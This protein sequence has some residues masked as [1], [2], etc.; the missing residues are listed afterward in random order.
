MEGDH[1]LQELMIQENDEGQRLDKYLSKYLKEAPKSFLYKMLRKKNIVLNKK[2]ADGTERL[3]KGDFVQLFLSEETIAKFRGETVLNG[4]ADEPDG[5]MPENPLSVQPDVLYE[6]KDVIFFSKPAG[7][8]SQKARPEDQSM[9]E[10]L[11]WYLLQQGKLK[12]EELITFHPGV[13]NRLDRNTS[14][15]IAAGKT[16]KGLQAMSLVIQSHGLKKY[17]QCIVK[18]EMKEKEEK[19][20]QGYLV[21]NHSHNRVVIQKEK[22]DGADYICTRYKPLVSR[23]GYTLLKVELITG[24]SHQI[25]AHLHS[26]GHPV[27]GDGKYGDVQV[28]KWF[29]KRFGLR[30]HLLHACELVFPEKLDEAVYEAVHTKE[31]AGRWYEVYEELAGKTISAPLPA[32]FENIKEQLFGE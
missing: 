26:I 13:C 14:G 6:T 5:E 10:Y 16:L 2:K 20:I 4:Q 25:R 17:Y 8:L 32:Q 19:T 22:T 1:S 31:E 27:V 15:I 23:D 30:H 7:V 18:G 3:C 28:N 11:N 12:K 21:K 29:R 9:V 24:K